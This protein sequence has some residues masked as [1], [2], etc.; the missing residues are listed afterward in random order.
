[1]HKDPYYM[2]FYVNKIYFILLM[3]DI[4]TSAVSEY[5]YTFAPNTVFPD[6]HDINSAGHVTVIRRGR[7]VQGIIILTERKENSVDL[8]V[9]GRI[10]LKCKSK[11]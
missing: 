1:M 10:I 8:D 3:L 11:N 2:C 9:D 7:S 6:I 4:R 5:G